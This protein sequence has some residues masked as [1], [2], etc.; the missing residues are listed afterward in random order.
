MRRGLRKGMAVRMDTDGG[1][2]YASFV[3]EYP[4]FFLVKMRGAIGNYNTAVNK[5]PIVCGDTI[6]QARLGGDWQEVRIRD[7]WGN[8]L[9]N[10]KHVRNGENDDQQEWR[11]C[12]GQ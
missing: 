2:E 8:V 12:D 3:R 1:W 9:K 7:R 4:Y 11:Q 6:F 5:L 10:G